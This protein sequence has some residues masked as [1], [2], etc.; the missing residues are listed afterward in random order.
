MLK[1]FAL[2]FLIFYLLLSNSLAEKKTIIKLPVPKY[3]GSMTV[4]EAILRRRSERTFHPQQLTLENISQ[5]L[6][7]GQ[8]IT[9][10]NWGFRAAPSAGSL[11]PLTLYIAKSDGIFEYVPD[12][13]KLIQIV[14]DDRRPSLVRASLGQGYIGEAPLVIII[15]GNFRITEAKYG[16]RAYRYVNMEVGHVAE[17]IHLQAVAMG[18]ISV[19]IGAFWDD[20][21]AKTLELPD[22]RDPYLILP[23]GYYQEPKKQ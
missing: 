14:K 2:F 12:G 23:V 10:P 5:L 17:N 20:V 4:E 13:H 3:S 6:W 15:T 21:V 16:Q 8:G 19:T 22:T 9:D 11:Y 18:M 1:K 7:A